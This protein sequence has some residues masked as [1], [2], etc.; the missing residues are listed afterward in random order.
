MELV[1]LLTAYRNWVNHVAVYQDVDTGSHRELSYL[2]LG[3]VG[4]AGETADVIKKIIRKY[5]HLEGFKADSP[6][7]FAEVRQRIVSELG[8]VMWYVTKLG[9][10][11]D[12]SLDEV[13][14]ANIKKLK[15]RRE[16]GTIQ[17]TNRE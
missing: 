12:I 10:T 9:D 15:E 8:D 4:E 13:M 14:H 6:E 1:D 11:F 17:D 5:N 16:Q 3:L 7:E 2:A